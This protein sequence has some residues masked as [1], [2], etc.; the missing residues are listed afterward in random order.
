[1]LCTILQML[2]PT[3]IHLIVGLLSKLTTPENVDIVLGEMIYDRASQTNRDIDVTIRYKDSSGEEI[4]FVGIQVKDHGRKLGSPDVEQL[5]QHFKDSP[6]IKKGGIVSASG[7]TKPAINKA[8]YHNVDLY[9]FRDWNYTTREIPHIQFDPAFK[10]H[11]ITNIFTATP[12]V[13]Y[14]I[15]EILTDEEIKE[16]KGNTPVENPDGTP[17]PDTPTISDLNNNLINNAIRHKMI[18]AKLDAA[19]V[20]D[21]I[22]IEVILSIEKPPIAKFREKRIE[23]KQ[24]HIT[25]QMEKIQRDLETKFKILVKLGDP[26]YQVGSA[27]SEMSDGLLMGFSTSNYDRSVK[28]VTVP[29]TERLKKKIYQM[30]I[31]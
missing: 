15:S 24:A 2:T 26:N 12:N 6:S 5:C 25:G 1:M 22:P 23:L 30:K 16:F 20:G 7:F 14:I 3:D 13:K 8:A 19:S 4:S 31:K 29:I 17:I 21:L 27:I 10:F 28:L 11:E 18:V 9:E